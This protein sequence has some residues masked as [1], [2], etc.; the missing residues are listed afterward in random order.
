MKHDDVDNSVFNLL[1][2]LYKLKASSWH[3]YSYDNYRLVSEYVDRV[4]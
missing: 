3:E 4:T 1:Y 2:L